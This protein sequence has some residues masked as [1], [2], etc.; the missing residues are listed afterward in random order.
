VIERNALAFAFDKTCRQFAM[1]F[2]I[3]CHPDGVMPSRSP[4]WCVA[5]ISKDGKVN[6]IS[7][8]YEYA[9]E[10]EKRRN[11]LLAKK[12]QGGKNP[13]VTKAPYPVDPRKPPRRRR[14]R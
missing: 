5:E 8:A 11:E 9:A 3:L 1:K 6:S 2:G 13:Q 14:N 7:P 12:E 10:A 4:Y